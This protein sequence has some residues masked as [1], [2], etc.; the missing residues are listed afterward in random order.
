M[1]S[2]LEAE[3]GLTTMKITKSTVIDMENQNKSSEIP[4]LLKNWD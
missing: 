4:I 1:P 2:S 3:C